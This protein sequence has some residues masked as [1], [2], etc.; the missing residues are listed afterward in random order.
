[1]AVSTFSQYTSDRDY[2]AIVR[3]LLEILHTWRLYHQR[4]V[5]R[6]RFEWLSRGVIATDATNLTLTRSVTV[7]GEASTAGGPVQI[8]PSDGELALRM[9]ARVD[10]EQKQP[11]GVG[12]D[13]GQYHEGPQ[14]E[15]LRDDVEAFADLDSIT[16]VY[17]RGYTRY[18][19]FCEIKHGDDD[20]VTLLSSNAHVDVLERL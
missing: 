6:K 9:A 15:A 1:M 5:Q 12:V 20:F 10:V 18:A 7:Q 2:S 8:D 14:F 11:V 17:D 4:G 19:R 13:Q 3:L 16:L